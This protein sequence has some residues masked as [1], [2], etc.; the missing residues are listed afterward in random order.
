MSDIHDLLGLAID[1]SPVDFAD[2]F[3]SIIGQRAADAIEAYKQDLAQSLYGQVEDNDEGDEEFEASP[4][5]EDED[6]LDLDDLDLEDLD[7]EDFDI[8]L[9]EQED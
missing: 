3:S 8:D 9:D 7:L 2:K 5:D 4:E 6:D 1:K